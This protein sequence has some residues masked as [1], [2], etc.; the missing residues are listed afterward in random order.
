MKVRISAICLIIISL[1]FLGSCFTGMVNTRMNR[2]YAQKRADAGP[3]DRKSR[4]ASD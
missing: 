4:G 1:L 3:A 2:V